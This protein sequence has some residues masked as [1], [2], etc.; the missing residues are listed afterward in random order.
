MDPTVRQRCVSNVKIGYVVRIDALHTDG[1][2]FGWMERERH[3][4]SS[5]RWWWLFGGQSSYNGKLQ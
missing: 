4:T 2:R 5:A 3:Q 1:E